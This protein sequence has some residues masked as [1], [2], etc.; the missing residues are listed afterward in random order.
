MKQMAIS[1]III[2]VFPVVILFTCLTAFSEHPHGQERIRPAVITE[3]VFGDS[4]DPAIWI[5]YSDPANSWVLGTDKDNRNGGIYVYDLSGKI[6][7]KK[8]ILGLKRI[9]N[10]DI[11]Q[12]VNLG[13]RILD[14]AV[15]TERGTHEI[16]VL[17]LPA[18]KMIDNGG[19]EVFEGEAERDPMGIAL[20]K[21]P[22]DGAV[23]AIVSRKTGPSGSYLWQYQ[24]TLD[25]KGFVQAKL[26]RKFGSFS[27]L[28]E[29][30][31]VA[32]DSLFGHVYYSDE[33][34]GI[35]QYYADPDKGNEELSLF[36]SKDFTADN[37]GISFY[38]LTDSSG[39][40]LV[41]DQGANQFKVYSLESKTGVSYQHTLLA[42]LPVTASESD[43]SEVTAVS[44]PG[45]EAGLF[46]AM[47]TDRSFHYYRWQDFV[48]YTNGKLQARANTTSKK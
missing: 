24:L 40:I 47:S 30:E 34:V 43:G 6:N 35:R 9:N 22:T 5:N 46:V 25:A 13:N 4:D 11:L 16:R 17:E 27:G 29:I 28:K 3:K 1:K 26:V 37:E 42:T 23:F 31:S 45:Y 2:A 48:S 33:Q 36:G 39:Y 21:R 12:G 10:I 7:R 38:Y 20:Y 41:S 14:I 8:S 18:M 15:A 19:I 32:V 44:L